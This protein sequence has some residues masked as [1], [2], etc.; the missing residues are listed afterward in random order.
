MA[1]VINN[2]SFFD[3]MGGGKG[4]KDINAKRTTLI[5][6]KVFSKLRF[7]QGTISPATSLPAI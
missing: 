7:L 1:N 4:T 5:Y 6:R 2:C 3:I